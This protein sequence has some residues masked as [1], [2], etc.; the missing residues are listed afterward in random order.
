M[1]GKILQPK[2]EVKVDPQLLELSRS[3]KDTKGAK[4]VHDFLLALAACNTIVPLVVDDT[5][6]STVKLL[7]YQG[8]SPDEQALAYAAA[9]YGFMLTERTSGHIVINIQGERQRYLFTTFFFLFY[10][11]FLGHIFGNILMII[12][13]ATS[14]IVNMIVC[15]AV[16]W[17]ETVW[18][19]IQYYSGISGISIREE[20][21]HLKVKTWIRK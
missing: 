8:E 14:V 17:L 13:T 11:Q 6:D 21:V 7:D 16:N 10:C 20:Y 2:M 4:H 18:L 9:A 15:Q 5:S 3:G 1:D 19:L 12:T